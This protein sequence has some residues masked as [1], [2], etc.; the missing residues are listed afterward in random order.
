MY[1]SEEE[2]QIIEDILADE[3]IDI[4]LEDERTPPSE[5]YKI[6]SMIKH[7]GEDPRFPSL[8][9]NIHMKNP[10]V[11]KIIQEINSRDEA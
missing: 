1:T 6:D 2:K 4:I 11:A 7:I 3:L 9:I 5:L 10:R 8:I